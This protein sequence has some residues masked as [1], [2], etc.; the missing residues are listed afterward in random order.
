MVDTGSQVS[1]MT[2]DTYAELMDK[3]K[4]PIKPLQ[5][6]LRITAANGLEVPYVG[7][8][9]VDIEVEGK[10]LEKKRHSGK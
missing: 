9:E 5:Q 1:M 6:C 10:V 2:E 3:N 8:F 7:Y 4:Q